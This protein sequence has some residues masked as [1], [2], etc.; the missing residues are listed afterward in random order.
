MGKIIFRDDR[1]A[2]GCTILVHA[3]RGGE[4]EKRTGTARL[5]KGTIRV[6]EGL[7]RY[8]VGAGREPTAFWS[9]GVGVGWGCAVRRWPVAAAGGATRRGVLAVQERRGRTNVGGLVGVVAPSSG[10]WR[11]VNARRARI[12]RGFRAFWGCGW[13]RG[14]V[15]RL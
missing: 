2:R 6:G 4:G 3:P 13:R 10:G 11:S 7:Y 14:V 5:P 9:H 15:V 8:W 12:L 1:K